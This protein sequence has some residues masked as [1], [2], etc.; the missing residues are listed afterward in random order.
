M[1]K[2]IFRVLLIQLVGQPFQFAVL[3]LNL[4]SQSQPSQFLSFYLSLPGSAPET[5][6]RVLACYCLLQ[7]H[8]VLSGS[9]LETF[10]DRPKPR[11]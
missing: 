4:F 5:S 7:P 11:T 2:L 6:V 1:I 10:D 8:P 3:V 9:A